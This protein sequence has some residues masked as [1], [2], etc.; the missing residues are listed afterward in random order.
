MFTVLVGGLTQWDTMK[1]TYYEMLYSNI[2]LP[3]CIQTLKQ[4]LDRERHLVMRRVQPRVRLI[5]K[6]VLGGAQLTC[7]AT[8]FYPRHIKLT[9]L[10]DSLPVDE[11]ELRG[12]SVLPNGNGLYQ[13]RKALVV[14]DEEL[15]RKHNYTCTAS[16]L[17]LDNHLQVSWR[18]QFFHSHRIHIISAPVG[19]MVFAVLLL[20]CCR[21]RQGCRERSGVR[22]STET[23]EKQVSEL[24]V[25][26]P[27]EQDTP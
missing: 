13:V 6:Q 10:R 18:A 16:H 19:L 9:L 21:R 17:S 2:Y 25:R 1:R 5:T 27:Q 11:D 3:F 20:L 8:E 22:V 4:L 15:Q 26:T 7:V 14:S 24:R 23:K 12:G